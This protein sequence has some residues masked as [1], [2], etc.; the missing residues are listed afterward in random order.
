MANGYDGDIKLSVSLS[1]KDIQNS[2]KQLSNELKNIFDKNAGKQLDNSF[3]RTQIQ[4]SKAVTKAQELSNAMDKLANKKIPT[5]EFKEMQDQVDK[6][7]AKLDR[8]KDTQDRFLST[9]GKTSS[10]TYKKMQ[11]DMDELKNTIRYTRGEM[12]D[13][14]QSGKAF[15][16]GSD[17]EEYRKM[18]NQLGDVNNQMRVLQSSAGKAANSTKNLGSAMKQTSSHTKSFG[19]SLGKTVLKFALFAFGVRSL[20]IAFRKMRA[21][22]IEGLTS[23]A[24]MN[25][26]MNAT[27]RSMSQL[28]SSLNYLKGALATAFA[29]ILN[30][31][32]PILSGFIKQLGDVVTMIGMFIARLTGAKSFTKATYKATN[33]AASKLG[34]GGGGKSGKSAQE[35]YDDA[36]KKA[37][38]KYDKKVAATEEKNAKRMA[39]AEEKEA[40]AAKKFAKEQEKANNKLAAFDD[41]NVLGVES[42]EE[43][44]HA[45]ADLLDMPEMEMPNMDDFL[46]GG[47]AGGGGAADPFGLEEIP[48]D[49]FKNEF[50][51]W[52]QELW[53]ALLDGFNETWDKL[54]LT[55]RIQTLKGYFGEIKKALLDIFTD[56]MVVQS[57]NTMMKTFMHMIGSLAADMISI[58]VSLAT[59][60]VGGLAQYL[61]EP[62]TT[63]QI[64]KYLIE[65]FNVKT[66]IFKTIE[67]LGFAIA[68]IFT[69]L[70]TPEALAFSGNFIGLFAGAFMNVTLL[71]N[72]LG[73]DLLKAISQPLIDNQDLI[74]QT[75]ENIFGQ[76]DGI[77][78]PIRE[79]VD[80]FG[81]ELNQF[82][83]TYVSPFI[84][85]VGQGLT[86]LLAYILELYNTYVKPFIDLTIS[87]LDELWT[88][89]IQPLLTHVIELLQ[90]VIEILQLLWNGVLVPLGQVIILGAATILNALS[91]LFDFIIV[92]VEL[93][94]DIIT[95]IL[96]VLADVL[97]FIVEVFTKGWDEAWTNL[98]NKV[99][100]WV[101]DIAKYFTIDYWKGLAGN[102]VE[103]LKQGLESGW[104]NF[105]DGAGAIG[106]RI[107][108]KFR[109]D[110]DTHSPSKKAE[111][112]GQDITAGLFLPF[113]ENTV[114]QHITPFANAILATLRTSL[115]GVSIEDV[116]TQ[117][118]QSLVNGLTAA[119]P[120]LD[121]FIVTQIETLKSTLIT[122]FEALKADVFAPTWQSYMSW[123][124]QSISNWWEVHVKKWFSNDKW[125]ADIY[126]PW[127]TFRNTKWDALMQWWTNSMTNWWN[128]NVIPWFKQDK[129]Q[130]QFEHIYRAAEQIAKK[131]HDMVTNF[132]TQVENA[133]IESC[134]HMI[135][136][137]EDLIEKLKEAISLANEVNMGGGGGGS[138]SSS[139]G[140]RSSSGG[141]S[142]SSGGRYTS[143]MPRLDIMHFEDNLGMSAFKFPELATGAVIP[144]N[145][146]FLAVL[147]DQKQGMNIETPLATMIEAFRSVM[148]EYRNP[149]YNGAT[150]EVD[151]ETFARLMLPYVMDEMRR[152]GYNTEIIEGV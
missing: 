92:G 144:P 107:I 99:S 65:M 81:Q 14:V 87:A 116:G 57:F 48:L 143:F 62:G 33:Y 80:Q 12:D 104:N 74:K 141:S 59:F 18:A 39:K 90:P 23:M 119:M 83:D 53:Q 133:V 38:E 127:E 34:G 68:N 150:M 67:D 82:Y 136:R 122:S 4:M 42:I 50:F 54:N 117:M 138:S 89:H 70:E 135:S 130:E 44:E 30:V 22:V 56:P 29:P 24:Q 98:K 8:L 106:K 9:G 77:I 114:A 86:D 93:I 45:Q 103:G 26:G 123:F 125:N 120:M 151:G 112:V 147:G 109:E 111:D 91:V 49:P 95:S 134:N 32:S 73:R 148:D 58:G 71:A 36:V 20:F 94:I 115:T 43:M 118:V 75:L 105:K 3:K 100:S 55:E 60:L 46:G 78:E 140:S 97:T 15:T 21:A 131:T 61:M 149:G 76:L 19:N 1:P 139:S 47:G 37:Q 137:V 52:L 84:L 121:T 41:L 128:N 17:T 40:K 129:W 108:S 31:V 25:G 124:D 10:N 126:R 110:T 152:Q 113:S 13:L 101:D 85:E 5:Q 102:I 96:Q 142:R 27:N 63:D 28:V 69:V 51:D 145:N 72:K 11:Y 88:N 7:K 79:T 64:K 16:L 132:A 146:K 6:A 2:A 35:K 66:D